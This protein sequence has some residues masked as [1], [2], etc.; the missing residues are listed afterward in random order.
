MLQAAA[1]VANDIV[2][3]RKRMGVGGETLGQAVTGDFTAGG[4]GVAFPVCNDVP[5]A[6]F[7][8]AWRLLLLGAR[9]LGWTC[10][11]IFSFVD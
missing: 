5:N 9:I 8:L 6:I 2:I 4:D 7:T 11:L 1:A 10:A 3:S